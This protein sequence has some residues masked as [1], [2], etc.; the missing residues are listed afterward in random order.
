MA[1]AYMLVEGHGEVAAAG[2]LVTRL[3]KAA[4][5]WLPWGKPIRWKNLHLRR[6]VESGARYVQSMPDA[7]AL[8]VLRD[9]DDACPKQSAPEAAAWLRSLAL[10]FPSALVLLHREYEVLFLPCIPQ[11]AGRPIVDRS[12]QERPGL[13]ADARYEGDWEDRRGVKEWLSRQ[14]VGSRRYKPTIDQLPMTRMIDLEMLRSADV[15]CFGTLER[16]L[17][18]LA[19]A[20]DASSAEVYPPA[21]ES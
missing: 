4:G 7:G 18:F 10:P 21:P 13:R 15:P 9:E 14:F 20:I 5:H 16:S 6:G 19:A 17:A 1:K 2:N 3:W 8:L 11:M 12:G